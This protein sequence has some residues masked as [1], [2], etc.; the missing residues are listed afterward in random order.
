MSLDESDLCIEIALQILNRP[1]ESDAS[2]QTDF[3]LDRPETPAYVPAKIGLDAETQICPGD[4]SYNSA[5]VKVGYIT[6]F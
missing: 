2:C 5:S 1:P 6:D 4:V 3:F